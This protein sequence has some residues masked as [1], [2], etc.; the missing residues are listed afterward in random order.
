MNLKHKCY[1]FT[2]NVSYLDCQTLY[3][4][5]GMSAVLTADSGE[6]VQVPIARLRQCI[7][8]QGLYGRFELSVDEQNK[9]IK[10]KKIF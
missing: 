2:L 10:F 6:R 9:F 4:Q 3:R 5:S 1:Y 8:S 7:T